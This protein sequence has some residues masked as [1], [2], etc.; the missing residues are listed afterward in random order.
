MKKSFTLLILTAL[1]VSVFA[2]PPQK[3][4]YQCVVRN[5]SGELVVNQTVGIRTAILQGSSLF[6]IVYAETYNPK[7]RTNA[8]GLLTIEIGSGV[9]STGNFSSINWQYGPFSLKTEIDPSGGTNYTI[10]GQSQILSVPYALYAEKTG[11]VAGSVPDTRILTINGI[12]QNLSADRSWNVGTVTSV[13]LSLPGIFTLAGSPVTSSGTLTAILNS[14]PANQVLASPNGS[15]G[16]P[17][18]RTLAAADI[19]NL[20]W[21]KITSGK[22]T[23][24]TGY[25][26]TDAFS[27]EG[28]QTI[29]G[30]KTFSN[31]LLVNGLTIGK[32]NS[33]VQSKKHR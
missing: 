2:Q 26:I 10:V 25:G 18:F 3:M 27:I 14:Q 13:G 11:S 23:T 6:I 20:D 4:S 21:S 22:P 28:D 15:S 8:N 9:P 32:G 30:I 12:A 16:I 33:S 5:S 24:L 17:D 19:P 31:D 7:P 29:S 1:T